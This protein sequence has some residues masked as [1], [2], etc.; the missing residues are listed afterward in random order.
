MEQKTKSDLKPKYSFNSEKRVNTLKSRV[1]RC[2]CKYCGGELKLRQII[3]SEYDEA[4]IEIFCK[5]CN[6][7][8]FGVEPEIYV[9]A[10]FFVEETGFN[11]YPD[12]DDSERTNQMTIAK[13]CEIIEWQNRNIGI[14]GP[15]GYNIEIKENE[16]YVGQCITISEENLNRIIENR[17]NNDECSNVEKCEKVDSNEG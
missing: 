3:F 17:K 4:R 8:E 14:L 12:L 5:K 15:E 10:R 2:V 9:N 13:I 1:N 6:R 7:I 16:C 11:C